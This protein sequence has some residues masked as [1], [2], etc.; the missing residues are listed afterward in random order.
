MAI[1]DKLDYLLETKQAIKQAIIDK[2][3]E[4]ADTD[5]FRSYAEKIEAIE[6][7]G[8]EDMLQAR[9]DA[10]NSCAYLFYNY[11]GRTLDISRLNT[12]NVTTMANMFYNCSNLRGVNITNFI[13]TNVRTMVNMFYNCTKLEELDLS[14]FDTSNVTG[15]DYM[16]K[17][18][19]DLITLDLSNFDTSNVTGMTQMFNS[20]SSLTTVNLSSFSS[21]NLTT[22]YY[23]FGRCQKLQEIDLSSFGTGKLTS[24]E[25]VFT[26]CNAMTRVNIGS[27][28]TSNVKTFTSLFQACYELT[29]IIG[30]INLLSATTTSV[31]F[32]SCRKLVNVTLKNIK[33]NLQLGSGTSWGHLLSLDSLTNTINELW[34][35]TGS[36]AKTLTIGSAN[37]AK[38]ANVYVKLVTITDEMRAEDEYIDNKKPCVVC[39]STDE[40]AMLILDYARNL[41]NWNIS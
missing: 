41:K 19:V 36:T 6:T 11:E 13:T 20:C 26:Q 25:G 37:L 40:G 29:D 14:S 18:C 2:G 8:G 4:V 33:V 39:E 32:D 38:L 27:L 1:S 35:M 7:G 22:M 30:V 9:V 10:T 24:F 34:D 17:S 15:M 23:M 31:M 12:N 28:D 3:Q 21:Q 5:T 16:F